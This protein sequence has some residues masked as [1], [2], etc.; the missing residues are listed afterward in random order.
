VY[1]LRLDGRAHLHFGVR[2]LLGMD[3]LANAAFGLLLLMIARPVRANI[4]SRG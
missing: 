2:G 4:S 1:M 3:A